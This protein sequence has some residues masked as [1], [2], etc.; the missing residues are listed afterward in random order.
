MVLIGT[1][2]TIASRIDYRTGK[3]EPAMSGSEILDLVPEI[4][5]VANIESKPLFSMYS[6]NMNAEHWQ[7]IAVAVAEEINKGA[8]GVLISHGTDTM[9]YTAA[10]LSFML[11]MFPN[12]LFWSELRDLPTARPPT[13]QATSL[14]VPDSVPTG[15]KRECLWS[16]MK[17]WG[18]TH[19]S[20]ISEPG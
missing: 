15:K 10:A 3:V 4:R 13:P 20:L 6:D 5:D 9:G 17:Q 18:T 14:Q 1:G 19:S 7:K 8:D 11:V 2:G 16:C 12:P